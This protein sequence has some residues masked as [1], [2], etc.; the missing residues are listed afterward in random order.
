MKVTKSV[1]L[2]G[3]SRVAVS[4]I[5]G[6]TTRRPDGNNEDQ[7]QRLWPSFGAFAAAAGQVVLVKSPIETT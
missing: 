5:A 2:D 7:L 3:K 6:G 4:H 1:T